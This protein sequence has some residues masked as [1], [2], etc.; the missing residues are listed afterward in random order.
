MV[1]KV[2]IA[3]AITLFGRGNGWAKEFVKGLVLGEPQECPQQ[4]ETAR[5]SIYAAAKALG[6]EVKTL[7]FN[8]KLWAARTK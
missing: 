8:K 6:Y 5:T 7:T 3:P 2:D 1:D 4:T